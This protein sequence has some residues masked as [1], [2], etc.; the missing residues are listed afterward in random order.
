MGGVGWVS[1]ARENFGEAILWDNSSLFALEGTG[2]GPYRLAELLP[3]GPVALFF[4]PG[5]NTPG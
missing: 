4:Y 2:G 3:R 1:D 5:D